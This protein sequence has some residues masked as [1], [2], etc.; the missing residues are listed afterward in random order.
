MIRDQRNVQI[1]CDNKCFSCRFK[2]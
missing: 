1:R 2:V